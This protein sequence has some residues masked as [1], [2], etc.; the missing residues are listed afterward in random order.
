MTCATPVSVVR[1]TRVAPNVPTAD[2][3]VAHVFQRTVKERGLILTGRVCAKNGS[4]VIGEREAGRFTMK[5]TTETRRHGG[6]GLM[7]RR[8]RHLIRPSRQGACNDVEFAIW[9]W[10]S[11]SLHPPYRA[12]GLRFT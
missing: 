2:T 6:R 5:L 12:V 10:V 8:V 3:A 1:S 11:L 4:D 9:R 7:S